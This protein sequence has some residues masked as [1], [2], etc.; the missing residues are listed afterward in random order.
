M[1]VVADELLRD[2]TSVQ[3]VLRI[4][5]RIGFAVLIGAILGAQRERQGKEAGLRTHML[6]ALG[7]A[8]FL[9]A[10]VQLGMSSDALSRVIQGLVT[11]IGFLGAGAILKLTSER[12]IKGLTTAAGIW[13]TASVSVAAALGAYVI[14]VIGTVVA[15]VVLAMLVRL[16][17]KSE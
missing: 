2:V 13:L 11:G 5:T 17:R 1:D 12:E 8:V 4:L 16:E 10:P 6:V 9:L 14:A 7:T 15:W 3:D